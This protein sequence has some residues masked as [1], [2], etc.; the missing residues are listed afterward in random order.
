MKKVIAIALVLACVM[1][2]TACGGRVSGVRVKNC[3]SAVYTEQEIQQ[4]IRVILQDFRKG[5]AGCTLT[6]IGYAGDEKSISY[7][8]YARQKGADQALVLVSEF[9][10]D[11]SG[12]SP[13]LNP[14]STYKGWSW[15]LVREKGGAWQHVDHGYG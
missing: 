6:V 13:S 7:M 12:R 5:F 14:N 4:A 15:I 3:Y 1:G 9:K 8:E 10:V 11:G 2:L